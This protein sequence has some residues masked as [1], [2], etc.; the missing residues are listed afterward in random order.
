MKQP[1]RSPAI[2]A[3]TTSPKPSGKRQRPN[4]AGEGPSPFELALTA[5]VLCKLD[6][7][8]PQTYPPSRYFD[9]AESLLAEARRY[10]SPECQQ[11]RREAVAKLLSG[12]LD[13]PEA[14]RDANL[15]I[16]FDRLL[17]TVDGRSPGKKQRTYLGAI[18]TPTG[19]EKALRRY[20]PK[21]D[22]TRIIKAQA[23]TDD[24]VQRLLRAKREAVARRAAKRVKGRSAEKSQP[25]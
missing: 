8:D 18:T 7:K 25:N 12:F 24:E 21:R 3:T 2:P 23:M 1:Q 19:L 17:W 9:R 15:A 16:P 5:I 22:A 14:L 4:A 10:L 6:N 20:F 13:S 11:Q